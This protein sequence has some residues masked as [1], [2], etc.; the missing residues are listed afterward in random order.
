MFSIPALIHKLFVECEA[1]FLEEISFAVK[2][3]AEVKR[4][5]KLE[6]MQEVRQGE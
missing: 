2:E 5:K 1:G 4:S 6:E 3:K